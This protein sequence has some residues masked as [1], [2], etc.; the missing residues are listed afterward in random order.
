[1]PFEFTD[2]GWRQF[3]EQIL[4]A[5]GDQ[6]TLTSVLSDM[7]DTFMTGINTN[8]TTQNENE[9]IK[10]ENQR[11]KDANMSLFLRVGEQQSGKGTKDKD[12]EPA[13]HGHAVDGFLANLFKKDDEQ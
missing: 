3:S 13:E 5:N 4:A 1:M 12:P 8:N 7:G 11:L 2:E 9:S 10:A 6:A